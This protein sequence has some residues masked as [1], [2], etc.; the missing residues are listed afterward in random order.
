MCIL[1]VP[2]HLETA[3]EH[4]ANS[5]SNFEFQFRKQST[6]S[7]LLI[8]PLSTRVRQAPGPSTSIF[9]LLS[10]TSNSDRVTTKQC[11]HIPKQPAAKIATKGSNKK[12]TGRSGSTENEKKIA[13]SITDHWQRIERSRAILEFVESYKNNNQSCQEQLKQPNDLHRTPISLPRS[14]VRPD[15]FRKGI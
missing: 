10:T 1:E 12:K 7:I 5:N 15:S 9:V 11:N 3:T 14:T 6:N 8:P 2:K 4:R 13:S